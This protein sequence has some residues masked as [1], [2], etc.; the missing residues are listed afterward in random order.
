METK[1]VVGNVSI[2]IRTSKSTKYMIIHATGYTFISGILK[3]EAGDYIPLKDQFLHSPNQYLVMELENVLRPGS[4]QLIYE[5][6]Y[7]LK[8][9]LVGFYRFS[10]QLKSG[11]IR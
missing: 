2:D 9:A 5:F 1:N 7:K 8:Y 6:S 10:Y 4:Y 11:E 3:N